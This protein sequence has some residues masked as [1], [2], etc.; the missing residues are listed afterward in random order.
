[1]VAKVMKESGRA[2]DLA[3]PYFAFDK[4]IL[5]KN[6]QSVMDYAREHKFKVRPHIKAHKSIALAQW[7]MSLGAN[8]LCAA[9]VSECEPFLDL[10]FEDLL[11]AYPPVGAHRI[12]KLIDIAAKKPLLLSVDSP[13]QVVAL[14]EALGSVDFSIKLLIEIDTGAKRCGIN[15]VAQVQAIIDAVAKYPAL[16]LKGA[17]LYNG[18]LWGERASADATFA[19]INAMW[20]PIYQAI[21]QG[22]K[23]L[24]SSVDEEILVS[25]A[26]T[27]SLFNSHKIAHVNEIRYGTCAFNDFWLV[28]MNYCTIADCAGA[29]VSTVIS[30][31]AE[32]R[33]MIDAGSKAL[34]PHYVWGP[35]NFGYGFIL[36]HPDALLFKLHEEIGWVDTSR[37]AN[38]PQIG[39]RLTIIPA[40]TALTL[41]QYDNFY[42]LENGALVKQ[43]VDAR[44]ML[45]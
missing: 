40:M 17:M 22:M 23:D 25:S 44:G 13:A 33:V 39:D 15:S 14:G 18:H 32:G 24:P 38:P 11:I 20:K 7:Q 28:K 1:M 2:R 42:L 27:P 35:E 3:T 41:N 37:C 5:E 31:A 4:T 34:S 26:S 36:E 10:D 29:V 45:E 19:E 9:K 8:G 30:Q 21:L 6:V 16:V 43:P 12:A